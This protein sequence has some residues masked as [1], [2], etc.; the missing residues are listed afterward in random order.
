MMTVCDN[1]KL[2]YTP[3]P[4]TLAAIDK[5]IQRYFVWRDRKSDRQAFET[6]LRLDDATLAD[7]GYSRADVEKASRLPIS[8]NAALYL[9]EQNR[10]PISS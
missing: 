2:L 4:R 10:K 6:L 5:L 1:Q 3:S 7:M 9:R 8:V